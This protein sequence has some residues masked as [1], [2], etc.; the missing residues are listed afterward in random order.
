MMGDL[1]HLRAR[2][3][4]LG[5]SERWL[6]KQLERAKAPPPVFRIGSSVVADCGELDAQAWKVR[7][8][9]KEARI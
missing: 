6:R 9:Q 4:Y 7:Q 5:K 8:Q 2:A 3:R 1:R